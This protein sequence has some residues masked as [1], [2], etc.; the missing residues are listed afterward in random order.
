M[1]QDNS[2]GLKW[3]VHVSEV[4]YRQFD[5]VVQEPRLITGQRQIPGIFV[6][7]HTECECGMTEFNN[8]FC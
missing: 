3:E 1:H 5:L 7:P 4:I 6:Q 8:Q 2:V